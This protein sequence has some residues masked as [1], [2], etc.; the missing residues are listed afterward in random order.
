MTFFESSLVLFGL[1]IVFFGVGLLAYLQLF[2]LLLR[3]HMQFF[4]KITKYYDRVLGIDHEV[5]P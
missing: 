1:F 2:G 5:I 4:P 3:F